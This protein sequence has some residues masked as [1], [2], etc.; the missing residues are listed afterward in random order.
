MSLKST[1]YIL[2]EKN[3]RKMV[4]IG[5]KES[6]KNARQPF[7]FELQ[8]GDILL[9]QVQLLEKKCI[10]LCFTDGNIFSSKNSNGPQKMLKGAKHGP[11]NF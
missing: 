8:F 11:Q 9:G 6:W 1:F 3:F 2:F 7:F 10:G 5:S 4:N